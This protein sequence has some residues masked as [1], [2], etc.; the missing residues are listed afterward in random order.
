MGNT[1]GRIEG[2]VAVGKFVAR[3]PNLRAAGEKRYHGRARFRGLDVLPV[4]VS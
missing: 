2:H 4:A 1:L 3:F